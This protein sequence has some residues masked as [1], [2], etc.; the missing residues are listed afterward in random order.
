MFCKSKKRAVSRRK[1]DKKSQITLFVI[2]ALVI[3]FAFAFAMYARIKIM[4]ATLAIQADDQIDDYIN[5]NYIRQYVNSCLDVIT[6]DVIT[7][8]SMQGGNFNFTD[9]IQDLNYTEFY[10]PIYNKTFNVSVMIEPNKYCPD[11]RAAADYYIVTQNPGEY[12]SRCK[13]EYVSNMPS[14]YTK[15]RGE[16]SNNCTDMNFLTYSGFFGTNSWPMLCNPG[17]ANTY[18]IE[19]SLVYAVSCDYYEYYKKS[20]QQLLEEEI[21]REVAK[22][23]N[24]TEALRNSGT[25]ISDIGNATTTVIFKRDGIIVRLQYPFTLTMQGKQPVTRIV[26]FSLNKNIPFKELYEYTYELANTDVR[27]AKFNIFSDMQKVLGGKNNLIRRNLNIYNSRFEVKINYGNI[28]NGYINVVQVRDRVNKIRGLPLT[29]TFAVRNR[30]PVLDYINEGYEQYDLAVVEKQ[31]IT[32]SPEGYDPDDEQVLKYDYG[33]WL[34]EYVDEY[35]WDNTACYPAPT[36][37]AYVIA[38]CTNRRSDISAEHNWTKSARYNSTGREAA[39]NATRNDIGFHKVRISVTDRTGLYDY[40]D[41][42]ILVFDL[43]EANVNASNLYTDVPS[44]F[45][46]YEDLYI[47]DGTQSTV[48]ALASAI[49]GMSLVSFT[50]NDSIEQINVTKIITTDLSTKTLRIPFEANYPTILADG[51]IDMYN[52]VDNAFKNTNAYD[53]RPIKLTVQNSLELTGEATFE[54]NVT[55]CLNHRNDFV[56]SYPFDGGT[57]LEDHLQ[58][59]HTCCG[60]DMNYRGSSYTCYQDTSYGSVNSFTDYNNPAIGVS[61]SPTYIPSGAPNGIY[62]NDIYEQSFERR[63]S[64]LRGNVCDGASVETRSIVASGS[65][66]DGN[67]PSGNVNDP[68]FNAE[69]CSGPS[70]GFSV[71]DQSAV[72]CIAYPATQ[73]FERTILGTGT[74]VC[75]TTKQ[76]SNGTTFYAYDNSITSKYMCDGQCDGTGQCN[77]PVV[78]SC[79]CDISYNTALNTPVHSSCQGV[80]YPGNNARLSTRSCQSGQT[81]FEDRCVDC[82]IQDISNRCVASSEVPGCS[83]NQYCNNRAPGGSASQTVCASSDPTRRA[84]CGIDCQLTPDFDDTCI[85]DAPGCLGDPDCN[86]NPRNSI[87]TASNPDENRWCDNSC[88]EQNCG[89]FKFN[90]GTKSCF[91]SCALPSQCSTNRCCLAAGGC[92]GGITQGQ[93]Y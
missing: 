41:V 51:T 54:V 20:M 52:I 87:M 3:F 22:C 71:D 58:A 80:P 84:R 76:R 91:T 27:D 28:S 81:W 25:N 86:N 73:S 10:D 19:G 83:A 88:N 23:V 89:N 67:G 14:A 75:T 13:S 46:S 43:P 56:P 11:G 5:K 21:S 57:T 39:Y 60:D 65:C 30:I 17:G 47:L 12:P 35:E 68:A 82:G 29:M 7:R 32:L 50:W 16:C 49:P 26:D 78:S 53:I 93:C 18:R 40:Q 44:N 33:G 74:G 77:Q 48:G 55:R 37:I 15:L 63:C 6:D 45:A 1:S 66:R 8:A 59:N 36:S 34:E 38:N 85:T 24:F 72:S 61:V 79:N 31:V 64:G 2:V 62:E 92:G 69:K 4:K 70:I 42:R 9:M 90:D